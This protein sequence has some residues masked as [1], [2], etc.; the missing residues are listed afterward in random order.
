MMGRRAF[1]GGLTLEL[2]AVSRPASAQPVAKVARVGYLSSGRS[3][4]G[5]PLAEA[6]RATL[7]ERGWVE[8]ENLVIERR[9]AGGHYERLRPL[10][11]EL[12]RLTVDVIFAPSAPAAQAAKEATATIPIVFH[13]LYDPVRAGLVASLARP[14]GNLTGNAGL[15]LELDRKRIELLKEVLPSLSS[16]TGLM[17]PAN[18]MTSSR[19]LE[20]EEAAQ[21]VKVQLRNLEV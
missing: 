4:S 3:P 16:A 15:G 13:V 11:A 14:G 7:R 20:T 21:A 12:V 10:A 18:P 1:V 9:G 19:Q 2:L 6:F 17:N 5:D 8:G